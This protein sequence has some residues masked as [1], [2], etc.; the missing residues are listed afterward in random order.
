M[1][2]GVTLA[3]YIGGAAGQL[4]DWWLWDGMESG[5]ERMPKCA[6][7][8]GVGAGPFERTAA[9]SGGYGLI[10]RNGRESSRSPQRT[11]T[12]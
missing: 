7:G 6:E 8:T 9:G 2:C 4:Y 10:Q 3:A 12:K 1:N 11:R 5:A